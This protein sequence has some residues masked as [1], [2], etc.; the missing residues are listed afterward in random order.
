MAVAPQSSTAVV[1]VVVPTAISMAVFQMIRQSPD[2]GLGDWGKR[3]RDGDRD[4][5]R[6]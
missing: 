1:T 5:E 6:D 3:E 2:D 4:R